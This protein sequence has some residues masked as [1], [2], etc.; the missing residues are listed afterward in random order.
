M[1]PAE[2][3]TE[4][5]YTC[6]LRAQI[7]NRRIP[8]IRFCRCALGFQNTPKFPAEMR[9]VEEADGEERSAGFPG[10]LPRAKGHVIFHLSCYPRGEL[11]RIIP[12][13][14]PVRINGNF[15]F[16]MRNGRAEPTV[17][18]A[19]GRSASPHTHT[20]TQTHTH[21]LPPFEDPLPL[22][23]A[24]SSRSWKTS[25]LALLSLYLACTYTSR[26]CFHRA[27]IRFAWSLP[28][29]QLALIL[30]LQGY[31]LSLLWKYY[32]ERW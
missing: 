25:C 26:V 23:L 11:L 24:N 12:W 31:N 17:D 3:H 27:R 2:H 9:E 6:I 14:K 10:D 16:K 13:K 5:T 30:V 7:Q 28:L 29:L 8:M 19:G 15:P 20:H 22:S 32:S 1:C 21:T 18:I 4:R